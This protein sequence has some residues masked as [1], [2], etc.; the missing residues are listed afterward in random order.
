MLELIVLIFIVLMS[1]VLGV[2]TYKNNP[3]SATNLSFV[4][5]S[6]SIIFWAIVMYL[7][8]NT[9]GLEGTLFYIRLS[10]VAGTV[11]AI[12]FLLLA[13]CFPLTAIPI[14]KKWVVLLVVMGI[15]TS[16]I[17]MSPYMFTGIV[18]E[19]GNIEP[20][21][22]WGIASFMITALG[23]NITTFIV[24]II[25]FIKSKGRK[26]E[27][28][29]F[30]VFGTLIMFFF[31]ILANFIAVIVLKTS[32]FIFLGPLFTLFFL[33]SVAYAILR[34]KLLD[35]RLF[36]A[37]AVSYTL[38]LFFVIGIEAAIM[39]LGTK[40]LPTNIDKTQVAFAGSILIVMSYTTINSIITKVT[41]R[42]FFKGRYDF[43]DV[44][45][46][47]STIMVTETNIRIL[48]QK[49][50]KV[51]MSQLKI[52][53][54][55]FVLVSD[56]ATR[57]MNNLI[58]EISTY[59]HD[60]KLDSMLHKVKSTMIFEELTSEPDKE[61]FRELNISMILPLIENDEDIGLLVLGPKSSGDLYTSRDI[62]LL[63]IF[64][65]QAAIA[66]KNADS[67]RKIQEFN[68]TLE[69][70]VMDR[71]HELEIAQASEL[72]LKDEFVFIATHDL[73]TPVTAIA[74][75]SALINKS[76][77]PVSPQL[78]SN[79]NAITEASNRLKVLVN[80]L[81]QVAR[82]DSGTIKVEV[83]N[84]DAKNIIESAIREVTPIASEKKVNIITA[85]GPDNSMKGDP[86][87]LA[88]ICENLMSN[89]VKYNNPGGNL[90]IS[91]KVED[92]KYILRFQDTGIGIPESEQKKVFAKFF[93]SEEP[94]VRQRPGTGL[95]LFVAR[96]LTEKMGGRISF[97][98]IVGQGTTFMLTFNRE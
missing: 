79:L 67:Y 33:G 34:H 72:K 42:I 89:G 92:N 62:D 30:V 11:L 65:P 95:G 61:I 27:Q 14:S 49:L 68:R 43:E 5:S 87:K 51:L 22:G 58:S 86:I 4:W 35:I 71:T 73:A 9:S 69:A 7:S 83:V 55:Y 29:R 97:E 56:Y 44:L 19:G 74:G 24:L 2:V 91:S 50:I 76:Q 28:L 52:S 17:A 46:M 3:N 94:E 18:E 60:P 25:K 59:I 38:L 31:L 21:V 40:L 81:L 23:S 57:P 10:M 37:R 48:D 20:T 6:A 53:K 93:R 66:L 41:E 77:E 39:W 96:M 8:V 80:D 36:V 64:A 1:G 54:A 88:E 70:K 12:S 85:L 90:T 16:V 78:K 98:S 75:F 84:I 63:E 32:S 15:I 13:I 26:K 47:L 45:K 82:S